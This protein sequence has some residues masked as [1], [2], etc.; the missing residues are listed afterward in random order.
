MQL[1]AE[2]GDEIILK[3]GQYLPKLWASIKC[4]LL[5]LHMGT[6]KLNSE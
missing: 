3:I 6:S 4:P 5:F 1:F 2:S